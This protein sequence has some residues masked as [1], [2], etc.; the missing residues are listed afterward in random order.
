MSWPFSFSSYL[1]IPVPPIPRTNSM[2][3]PLGWPWWWDL[4]SAVRPLMEP[5]WDIHSLQLSPPPH[6]HS[7]S[8]TSTSHSPA[9]RRADGSH[10]S[11]TV[12]VCLINWVFG[13]EFLPPPPHP[14][15]TASAPAWQAPSFHHSSHSSLSLLIYFR[16]HQIPM[17]QTSSI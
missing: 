11:C 7:P 17:L 15:P 13:D 16:A 14:T 2:W 3:A 6:F 1:L 4:P 9:C 5:V 8:P 10:I 12:G